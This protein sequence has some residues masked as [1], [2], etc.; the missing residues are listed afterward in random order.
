VS[1]F[2]LVFATVA[3]A[4]GIVA[5]SV[6]ARR[7]EFRE[8]VDV[9]L[10]GRLASDRIYLLGFASQVVG[11]GLA[12]LA[13][14]ELPLFLVQAGTTSAV[15]LAAVT[16]AVLMGWRVRPA[17]IAALVVTVLGLVLLVGAAEPGVSKS[18]SLGVGAGLAGALVLAGVLAVPASRLTGS[19]G[20][21]AF[22][23]LA[24]IAFAVLAIGS[25]PLAAQPL[26]EIPFQPLAWL[27]IASAVVGQALLAAALQRGAT[28]AA[29]ASMDS[30]TV[31]VS[32]AVGLLLLGDRVADGRTGWLAC[33]L[34]LV[35]AGVVAMAVA[36]RTTAQVPEPA[37]LESV[38]VN[39]ETG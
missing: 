13:R 20:S 23:L 15:V 31:I 8:G 38:T 25:R 30:M 14:A 11:F 18:I 17:E 39:E 7:A 28:T 26:L 34:T 9:G 24:G 21:I 6:A 1:Y 35:V 5:Q 22:G 19:T 33:G 32:S 37:P 12:F 16:G 3:Y 10:L 29:M 4:V 36:T 2:Y 27:V